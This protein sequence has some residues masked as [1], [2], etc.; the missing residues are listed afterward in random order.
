M[1]HQKRPQSKDERPKFLH[2]IFNWLTRGRG[3][4]KAKISVAVMKLRIWL[5]HFW[6]QA[7]E[8]KKKNNPTPLR[9]NQGG[10]STPN[11]ET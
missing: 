9:H 7:V 5:L 6:M 2:N 8:E 4:P 11:N 10:K 1:Q 3:F